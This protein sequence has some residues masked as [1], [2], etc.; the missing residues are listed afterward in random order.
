MFGQ[1]VTEHNPAPSP[2]GHPLLSGPPRYI[3]QIFTPP[4]RRTHSACDGRRASSVAASPAPTLRLLSTQHLPSELR[5]LGHG[6]CRAQAAS[7]RVTRLPSLPSSP[8]PILE[9]RGLPGH[10][11][12]LS[13][14]LTARSPP[15]PFLPPPPPSPL[16]P[17][18]RPPPPHAAP[19][20]WRPLGVA[21]GY[22]SPSL[23]RPVCSFSEAR[24]HAC[25]ERLRVYVGV[26][27]LLCHRKVNSVDPEE[28]GWPEGRPC[29][30]GLSPCSAAIA[31]WGRQRNHLRS[32]RFGGRTGCLLSRLSSQGR[33]DTR[34]RLQAEYPR[35]QA[36][37]GA[38]ALLSEG[39]VEARPRRVWR[40]R[41]DEARQAARGAR[42]DDSP[43]QASQARSFPAAATA[44]RRRTPPPLLPHAATATDRCRLLS[45]PCCMCRRA[46]RRAPPRKRNSLSSIAEGDEEVERLDRWMDT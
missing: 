40:R 3:H 39:R 35:L 36:A 21:S 27:V 30:S 45:A 42:A 26:V 31:E 33:V 10:Q 8:A 29:R 14:R 37:A 19:A 5:V 1:N 34:M 2:S 9:A 17:W 12:T 7:L 28:R 11:P 15:S 20:V 18:P 32:A 22:N 25:A 16:Q 4:P 13:I 38:A 23:P 6:R 44:R 24:L 43:R 41:R 46:L